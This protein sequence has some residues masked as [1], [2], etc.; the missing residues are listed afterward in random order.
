[1]KQTTAPMAI[2]AP[3]MNGLAAKDLVTEASITAVLVAIT[4][5]PKIDPTRIA[6]TIHLTRRTPEE[7][8]AIATGQG[9]TTDPPALTSQG[10]LA[11][12]ASAPKPDLTV[13]IARPGL[14]A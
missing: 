1:M 13:D 7:V 2:L 6:A 8:P 12:V 14:V 11:R 3:V 10:Q 4:A 9:P 5:A